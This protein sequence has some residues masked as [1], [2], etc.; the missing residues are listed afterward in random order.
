MKNMKQGLQKGTGPSFSICNIS[1]VESAFHVEQAMVTYIQKSGTS[2]LPQILLCSGQLGS[3]EGEAC[4]CRVAWGLGKAGLGREGRGHVQTVPVGALPLSCRWV[5]S[6]DFPPDSRP[7]SGAM[8]GR[9]WEKGRYHGPRRGG[10][11]DLVFVFSPNVTTT[12]YY[13]SSHHESS[14]CARPCVKMPFLLLDLSKSGPGSGLSPAMPLLP[15]VRG[16]KGYGV[17][18]TQRDTLSTQP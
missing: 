6:T 16:S 8:M 1:Q 12:Q 13:K 3:K 14:L 9:G 15:R 4:L 11:V 2:Q 18:P 7:H 5:H 17:K 10:S